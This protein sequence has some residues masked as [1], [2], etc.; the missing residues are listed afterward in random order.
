LQDRDK[1]QQR[2]QYRRGHGCAHLRVLAF[3]DPGTNLARSHP[4]EALGRLR[5]DLRGD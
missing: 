1:R 4:A 2:D 5:P 3:T